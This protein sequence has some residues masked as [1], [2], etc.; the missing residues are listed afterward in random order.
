MNTCSFFLRNTSL[1][2]RLKMLKSYKHLRN[3]ARL[4][5]TNITRK[6]TFLNIL[7]EKLQ[8]A[9][10]KKIDFW[11]VMFSKQKYMIFFTIQCFH[12]EDC[13]RILHKFPQGFFLHQNKQTK[14]YSNKEYMPSLQ[15][16][17]FSLLE[18]WKERTIKLCT[19]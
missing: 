17:R 13:K 1:R 5:L 9:Y 10:W 7:K 18:I 2:N 12:R 8:L 16:N 14:S 4:T 11:N 19:L 6:I 15:E 3:I